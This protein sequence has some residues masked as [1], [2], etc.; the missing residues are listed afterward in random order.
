[1]SAPMKL[2]AEQMRKV[3]AALDALTEVTKQ[4]GVSLTPYSRLE[5]GLDDNVLHASWDGEAYVIDDR[6]GD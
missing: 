3:A 5:L 4:F 2:T 1:M 6:N